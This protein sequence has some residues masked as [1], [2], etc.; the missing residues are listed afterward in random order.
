[1]VDNTQNEHVE[2]AQVEQKVE[3]AKPKSS[4]AGR[5]RGGG[6]A[7]SDLDSVRVYLT[8][9]GCVDL[10]SREEEVEI[11]QRIDASRT[12]VLDGVLDTQAGINAIIDLPRQ[13]RKG[14]RSLR[15]ILDG[16]SNQEPDQSTGLTGVERIEVVAQEIKR[17]ARARKRSQHRVN[18]TARRKNRDYNSELRELTIR[19]RV[20][21]NVI[22]E[23]ADFLRSARDEIRDWREV[24]SEYASLCGDAVYSIR[25]GD[26]GVLETLSGHMTLMSWLGRHSAEAWRRRRRIDDIEVKVGLTTKVYESAFGTGRNQRKLERAK[27]DMILAN[28]DSL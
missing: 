2:G 17:V 18:K 11:A 6:P 24:L 20:N 8:G 25:L 26:E 22:T 12:A 7:D 27:S 16:S 4:G 10:L 23:I 14:L 21:W 5:P 1:M 13:V 28:Q 19:M 15:Q 3:G 9:I